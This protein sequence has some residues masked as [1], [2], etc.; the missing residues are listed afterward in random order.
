M[1]FNAQTRRTASRGSTIIEFAFIAFLL[2]LVIFASIEFDRMLL[3]YTTMA[4]AAHVGVRYAIV[5]G[6]HR[7]GTGPD[8]QSGPGA[9]PPEV[10]NRVKYYAAAGVLDTSRLTVSVTYPDPY[11]P[12]NRPGAVVIVSVSYPYD[13]FTLLP[14]R[15]NLRSTS[16]GVITF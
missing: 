2:F 11:L 13:P 1:R 14:L 10:V 5:H 7:T 9:D 16:E 3:V 8:G 12:Q 15:V 6:S 4:N